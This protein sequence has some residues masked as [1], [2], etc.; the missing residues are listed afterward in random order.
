M[1]ADTDMLTG[2]Y[3]P[4]ASPR[5]ESPSEVDRLKKQP[6]LQTPEKKEKETKKSEMINWGLVWG[7]PIKGGGRLVLA[8]GR[9]NDLFGVGYFN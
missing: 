9:G 2:M 3:G 8:T 7:K 4:G 5:E 1:E 6:R